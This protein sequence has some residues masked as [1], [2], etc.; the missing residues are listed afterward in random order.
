MSNV[1]SAHQYDSLATLTEQ[2]LLMGTLVSIDE[3]QPLVVYGDEAA[4]RPSL[5]LT[6]VSAEHLPCRVLLAVLNEY[7]SQTVILGV[8]EDTISY[9]AEEA[10]VEVSRSA[11]DEVCVDGKRVTVEA[12]EE[13]VLRCGKSSILLNKNGKIILKGVDLVNRAARTNKIKGASVNIN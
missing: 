9:K 5:C 6:T 2:R 8:V 11:V 1:L 10:A 13:I 4:P 7:A 3:G 12:K